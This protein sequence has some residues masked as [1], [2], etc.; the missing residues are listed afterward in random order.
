MGRRIRSPRPPGVEDEGHGTF[1]RSFLWATAKPAPVGAECSSE[2]VCRLFN[3]CLGEEPRDAPRLREAHRE[4]GED[5]PCRSIAAGLRSDHSQPARSRA[6]GSSYFHYVRHAATEKDR[7]SDRGPI[8]TF[9]GPGVGLVQELRIPKTL[10]GRQD[11]S[12][13]AAGVLPR[14]GRPQ[15]RLIIELRVVGDVPGFLVGSSK[16]E[17]SHSRPDPCSDI[18]F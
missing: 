4:K 13:R 15:P 8:A 14:Y 17:A 16:A 11:R 9:S 5:P 1:T 7:P 6:S 18:S 10:E 3:L 2:G 12:G